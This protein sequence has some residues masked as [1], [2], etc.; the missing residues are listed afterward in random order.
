MKKLFFLL[1]ALS[2]IAT[3]QAQI[4]KPELQLGYGRLTAP[5]T[6][7]E[8]KHR[9]DHFIP[10]GSSGDTKATS[11]GA[12][13]AGLYLKLLKITVGVVGSYEKINV[14]ENHSGGSLSTKTII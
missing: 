5:I 4:I 7:N 14:T 8:V 11:N 12:F 2:G 10:G 6:G 9:I 3:A 13:Q 1:I